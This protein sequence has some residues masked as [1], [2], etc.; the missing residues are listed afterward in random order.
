MAIYRLGE[1]FLLDRCDVPEEGPVSFNILREIDGDRARVGRVNQLL[2][3]IYGSMPIPIGPRKYN[4]SVFR[5]GETEIRYLTNG[6]VY[7]EMHGTP[8]EKRE[9]IKGL[10][11][12][13]G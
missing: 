1:A 12:K 6:G 8:A 5:I 2:R 9:K 3:A 7:V 13:L 11:T 4:S 10:V